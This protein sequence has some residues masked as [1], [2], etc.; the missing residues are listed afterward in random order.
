MH[1]LK[2]FTTSCMIRISQLFMTLNMKGNVRPYPWLMR[3]VQRIVEARKN[4]T[5]KS[6]YLFSNKFNFK[7]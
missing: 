4:D 2:S 7:I 3:N 5:V 1:E 6:K